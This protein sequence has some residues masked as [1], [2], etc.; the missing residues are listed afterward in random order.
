MEQGYLSLVL[1]AHLPYVRHP[2]RDDRLEERWVYEAMLESYIPLLMVFDK[3]LA[4]GIDYRLTMS[5]SPTLLTMLDDPLIQERFMSYLANL[6]ELSVKEVKRTAGSPAERRLALMYL[7]RFREIAVYCARHHY[8]LVP[9]LRRLHEA[10]RLEL[11]TC[12]ATHAY[13]PFLMTEEAV[14]AQIQTAVMT[15]QEILGFRP[16][17]IWLPECA[18]A[19]GVDRLLAEAGLRFFFVENHAVEH[20]TPIPRRG[21]YAPLLT[22]HGVAA[23]ARDPACSRQ[24]WSSEVGYPGDYDYR[25]FYR[26]IGYDLDVDYLAPHLHP[27]GIR[28]HTGLKYH[29]ITGKGEQKDWY[30]PERARDKAAQHASHFLASRVRQIGA[31]AR[32]LDRKPVIVAPYDA[33]LFGHWWYEGPLFLDF[34]CRR[35]AAEAPGLRMI[36][37]SDYLREYPENDRARLPFSS[38]GRSGYGE[39]WLNGK[40][41]WIYRHLHRAEREMVELVQTHPAPTPL[42]E[43]VLKQAA[44]ELM[45]AQSSDWA[46]IMD[47]QTMVDYAVG[48]THDHLTRFRQLSGWLRTGETDP[49]ALTAME[50]ENQIFPNLLPK[51]YLPKQAHKVNVSHSVADLSSRGESP[52]RVLML[53]WE[54]P[55][56]TVGGLAKAVY[57]LARHLAKE[58]VEVHVLT[59][60]LHAAYEEER[61]E[62]IFVRRVPTFQPGEETAFLDWVFQLNLAMMD[63]VERLMQQGIRFDLLHAH[64]WLVGFAALEAKRRFGLPLIATIHATEHGRNQ[65]IHTPLQQRIHQVE[66]ELAREAERVIVCSRYMAGEVQRLF[67][68]PGENISV[69]PNGIERPA[70]P[71]REEVEALRRRLGLEG[72]VI[73]FVGRLVREKGVHLLLEAVPAILAK[74]PDVTVV[75]AGTGPMQDELQALAAASGISGRV[76]F[77]GFVD[78][79]TRN[80]LFCL[81]DLAVFPSLYEP[82]GIVALEAMA[83]RTPLLVADT[84]GL[85][86]I[87]RHGEN[88]LTMYAGD[89]NSLADQAI[90][91]LDHPHAGMVL[92]ERAYAELTERYDWNRLAQDTLEQYRK[93]VPQLVVW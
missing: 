35:I 29:R 16:Q 7:E 72:R 84:G 83:Y 2:E 54:Y 22:A 86:E 8:R 37:P 91:L 43:R 60:A 56:K 88:G 25:E 70:P 67:E 51:F 21:L 87:V 52:T 27:S 1:H 53:C 59:S 76:R 66:R 47:N 89:R 40:N 74:H 30:N 92:A 39:V 11:I 85:A 18:Y 65:G 62:G 19:P 24:V 46:F 49:A 20:A 77:L 12:A 55:P 82:F 6:T 5:V 50:Q 23:F 17:G 31:V 68:L 48:R 90:W 10:G 9:V 41:E 13:L 75:V 81:A 63:E 36:S 79:D 73:Y 26:D 93:L 61:A 15:H 69:I 3:L 71:P 78:D 42:Q 80:A 14:R 4:D 34:L 28:I 32:Q 57:D 64:D 58:N 33:E 38:W 44:R 45:L